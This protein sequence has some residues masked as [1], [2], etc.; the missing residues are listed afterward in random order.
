MR[1]W[2][3]SLLAAGTITLTGGLSCVL[4]ADGTPIGG[5]AEPQVP[6]IGLNGALPPERTLPTISAR[7]RGSEGL[8]AFLPDWRSNNSLAHC[9]T[10]GNGCHWYGPIP[11]SEQFVT[12]QSRGGT[13]LR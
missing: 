11:G 9:L 6:A 4:A 1:H 10:I 5:F 2:L 3:L 8:P 7:F 12:E 13:G